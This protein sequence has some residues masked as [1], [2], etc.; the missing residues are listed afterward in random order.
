MDAETKLIKITEWLSKSKEE[1]HAI[2]TKTNNWNIV[3]E[4]WKEIDMIDTF[5][6]F[7][8]K[9]EAQDEQG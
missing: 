3:D 2:I 9:L 5:E 6:K 1:L 4:C 7:I 8:A